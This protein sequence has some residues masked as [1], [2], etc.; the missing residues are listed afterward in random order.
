MT[1]PADAPDDTGMDPSEDLDA[2][3]DEQ[4]GDGEEETPK[5]YPKKTLKLAAIGIV[6]FLLIG[7]TTAYFMG[8]M[9]AMLGIE[10]EKKVA[11]LQLGKPV[12]FELPQIKADL[13][14]GEC[15]APFL[16]AQFN[17]QLSSDDIDRIEAGQDKLMEQVILHLRDQDRQDLV[18]K[19]GADK[20][21][22]DLVNIVNNV[23]APSRIHGITFKE[24]VLQ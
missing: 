20:L 6:A 21:R 7:G 14:T 24:F 16:R 17:I 1:A 5:K 22:F 18:G 13:K 23:I 8:W 3:E 9:H 12:N 2:L 4:D 10:Q 15:K 11:L 19:A